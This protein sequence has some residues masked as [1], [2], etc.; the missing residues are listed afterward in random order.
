[1]RTIRLRLKADKVVVSGPPHC[2]QRDMQA[3]LEANREWLHR[4][5]ARMRTKQDT[6]ARI[7]AARPDALLLRGEWVPV[8]VL[9]A[10]PGTR[11]WTWHEQEGTVRFFAPDGATGLT[12]D[13]V[14]AFYLAIARAELPPRME[15]AGAW[16]PTTW[17]RLFIRSQKTKWGT[18]SSK[19]HISLNWRLVKAPH[20]VWEY[21]MVHELCHRIEFNHSPAFWAL[22]DRCYPYRKEAEAWLDQHGALAMSD[23]LPQ[24]PLEPYGKAKV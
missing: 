5:Y 24:V 4:S 10:K 12:I 21:L 6:V 1:M 2:T 3:F 22:I 7:L 20:F 18:C 9:Q 15:M 17:N 13:V 16:V 11:R 14:N 8:R 19:G 23:P